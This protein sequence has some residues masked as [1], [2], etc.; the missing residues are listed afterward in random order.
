MFIRFKAAYVCMFV[1][2][3]VWVSFLWQ[4][5]SSIICAMNFGSLFSLLEN[6]FLCICIY[7]F[8]TV[9]FM[10]FIRMR[11]NMKEKELKATI[12]TISIYFVRFFC[13]FFFFL[14]IYKGVFLHPDYYCSQF[15]GISSLIFLYFFFSFHSRSLN[16]YNNNKHRK[17]SLLLLLSTAPYCSES[18]DQKKEENRNEKV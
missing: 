1:R 5:C 6:Y 12:Y 18:L 10:H 17:F 9:C 7:S 2:T 4:N 16:L 8:Y 11:W 14:F 15:R 3:Y 13:F